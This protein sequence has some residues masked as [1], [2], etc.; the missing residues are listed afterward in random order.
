MYLK[1]YESFIIKLFLITF[2]KITG[3]FLSLILIINVFEEINYFQD[4][5]VSFL[6]PVFLTFLNTP[7]VLYDVF[8]FIFLISTQFFFINIIEK[9]E[10]NTFKHA[11]IKNSQIVKILSILSF[12][13]GIIIIIFYYNASSKLKNSYLKIKNS[14]SN[15]N[16]YLAVVT[17]NGLW[18]KDEIDNQINIINAE[19]I[20]KEYLINVTIS[21]LS[22]DFNLIQNIKAEKI[23]IQKN[24]WLIHSPIITKTNTFSVQED[25]LE[26]NSNFNLEKINNL[27]S[28]LSSLTLWEL[29]RLKHDYIN[30][31]YS[32]VEINSQKQKIFSFPV[33][34]MVMTVLSAVL[35]LNIKFNKS[36]VFHIILGIL[37]S[38]IIYYINYF[39]NL[40]GT[41]GRIPIHL[42]IWLPLLI[43]IIFCLI[44][45]TRINEK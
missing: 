3:V 4:A 24:L 32:I 16:K 27:F 29:N 12:F 34:L 31:G 45:L 28:N 11:G 8:P 22:K 43:L 42:S 13:L 17:E 1:T 2:F 21:Q 40:I 44:G 15:D 38:S 33:Y 36:R 14:F 6:Y 25:Y 19:K 35:M 26:F 9:N 7:S 41:N 10:L 37:M 5:K 30:L 18:I 20:N 39:I 23:N